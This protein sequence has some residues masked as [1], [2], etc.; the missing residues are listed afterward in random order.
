[1]INA[2]VREGGFGNSHTRG[3]G[4]CKNLWPRTSFMERPLVK[5]RIVHVLL[6]FVVTECPILSGG[7][8]KGIHNMW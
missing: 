8:R 4:G 6:S 7:A 2:G 5:Y 3:Q 1:M